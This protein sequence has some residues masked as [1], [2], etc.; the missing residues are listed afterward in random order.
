MNELDDDRH[1]DVGGL[2]GLLEA[3][4]Q[5]RPPWHADAACAGADLALFFPERGE[6]TEPARALCRTC[7]VVAPC[8]EEALSYSEVACPGIWAGT[9]ARERRKLRQGSLSTPPRAA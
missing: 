5:N 9:S 3:I 7:P 4:A 2:A 8:L 6:P 1:G